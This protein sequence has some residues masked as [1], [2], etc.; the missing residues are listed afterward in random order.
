M[1][2]SSN[3][4]GIETAPSQVGNQEYMTLSSNQF[5][6]ETG[7][8]KA[9]RTGSSVLSSNQFGIETPYLSQIRPTAHS[10]F[11]EPVW[12]RNWGNTWYIFTWVFCFHRTSLESKQGRNQRPYQDTQGFHRTS[13]ESK[14]GTKWSLELYSCSFHRTSL[15]SKRIIVDFDV[16]YRNM[17]SS[18]QFGIETWYGLGNVRRGMGFHRTSLESKLEISGRWVDT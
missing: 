1:R 13:L 4:F 17:L 18:N 8:L 2:L 10:A 11:I 3:Q 5:G 9:T 16:L 12:N 6:I 15:E 7:F 14:L